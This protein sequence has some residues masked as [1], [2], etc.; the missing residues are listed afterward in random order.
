MVLLGQSGPCALPR[1][2][3]SERLSQ[4]KKHKSG[5]IKLRK[6]EDEESKHD[7]SLFSRSAKVFRRRLRF[8]RSAHMHA[9]K[10][11]VDGDGECKQRFE[12]SERCCGSAKLLL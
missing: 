12:C 1:L 8:R 2:Q 5:G 11:D 10:G 6:R 3:M 9:S 7:R 4:Q